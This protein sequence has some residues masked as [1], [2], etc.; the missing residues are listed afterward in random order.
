[1]HYSELPQCRFVS[2]TQ[3]GHRDILHAP[4]VIDNVSSFMST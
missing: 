1:L 2:L 4:E 3:R